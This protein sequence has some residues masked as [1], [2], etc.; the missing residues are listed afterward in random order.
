M[1]S[2]N[3]HGLVHTLNMIADGALLVGVFDL[4]MFALTASKGSII[5]SYDSTTFGL[6]ATALFALS[7]VLSMRAKWARHKVVQAMDEFLVDGSC[8]GGSC[9]GSWGTSPEQPC[10]EDV[11][12]GR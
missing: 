7:L 10:V 8:C 9:G 2:G 12:F 5:F 4:I 3:G 1:P 6:S 11:C